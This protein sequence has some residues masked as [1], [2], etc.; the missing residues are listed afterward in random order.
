MNRSLI[1]GVAVAMRSMALASLIVGALIAS[2]QVGFA[3]DPPALP[4]GE[5]AFKNDANSSCPNPIACPVNS[6]ICSHVTVNQPNN[7]KTTSCLCLKAA[8]V[9]P[10]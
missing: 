6:P 1:L 7:V 9:D 5:C 10:G 3:D 4:T 8:P 2:G